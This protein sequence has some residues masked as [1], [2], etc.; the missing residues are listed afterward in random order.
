MTSSGS[1]L[2]QWASGGVLRQLHPSLGKSVGREEELPLRGK[3]LYMTSY[4]AKF[5]IHHREHLFLS[6]RPLSF[7]GCIIGYIEYNKTDY[8]NYAQKKLPID[9]QLF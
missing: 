3:Y 8:D 4:K 7:D 1:F 5:Y 6:G 2:R 9:R